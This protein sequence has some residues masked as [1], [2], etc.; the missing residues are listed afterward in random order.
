MKN[1]VFGIVHGPSSPESAIHVQS[2]CDSKE[3][4]LLETRYD[5]RT[6]Q[7]IINLHPHPEMMSKMF[8]DLVTE[9]GWDSFTIVYQSAPW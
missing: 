5:P 8:F 3:M 9:W 4:P 6:E 7:P 1:G 2:I